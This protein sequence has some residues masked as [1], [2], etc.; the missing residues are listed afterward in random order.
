MPPYMEPAMAATSGPTTITRAVGVARVPTRPPDSRP[1]EPPA[2]AVMR[3]LIC[4]GTAAVVG[5]AMW[6]AILWLL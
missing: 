4:W 6:A 5:V 1:P 2:E 3:R